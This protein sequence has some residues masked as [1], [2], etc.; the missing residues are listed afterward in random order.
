[1]A[2][3]IKVHQSDIDRFIQEQKSKLATERRNFEVRIYL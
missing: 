2:A 1:M 3:T